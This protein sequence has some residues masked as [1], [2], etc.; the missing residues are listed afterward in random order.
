MSDLPKNRLLEIVSYEPI[1]I[2]DEKVWKVLLSPVMKRDSM[3][4]FDVL[5]N[6]QYSEVLVKATHLMFLGQGQSKGKR[7]YN[8]LTFYDTQD[9]S[10]DD[11]VFRA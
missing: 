11:D 10:D 4:D 3:R 8:K 2:N 5:L 9:R 1:Q 6:S 7:T